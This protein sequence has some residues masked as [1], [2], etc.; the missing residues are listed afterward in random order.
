[1]RIRSTQHHI[2]KIACLRSGVPDDLPLLTHYKLLLSSLP[3]PRP[4][5]HFPSDVSSCSG[6]SACSIYIAA[7]ETTALYCLL[8]NA[9]HLPRPAHQRLYHNGNFLSSALCYYNQT[10]SVFSTYFHTPCSVHA[11]VQTTHLSRSF[12]FFPSSPLLCT[13]FTG[14]SHSFPTNS[15]Q[16]LF[17]CNMQYKIPLIATISGKRRV[18]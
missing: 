2:W 3:S 10:R 14:T 1:M 7:T 17:P 11:L 5:K 18:G 16:S 15:L 9:T 8:G 13:F 6:C 12:Q 4:T